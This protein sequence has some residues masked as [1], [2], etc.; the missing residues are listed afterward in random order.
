ME[1]KAH[2]DAVSR[3]TAL[4]LLLSWACLLDG[5]GGRSLQSGGLDPGTAAGGPGLGLRIP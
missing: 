4:L 2:S 3:N 1:S 5:L